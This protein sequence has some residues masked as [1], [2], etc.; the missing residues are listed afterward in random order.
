[1]T[2]HAE[3]LSNS[4]NFAIV[5]MPGRRFPGCWVAADTM[6]TWLQTLE[7]A[8]L[9]PDDGGAALVAEDLAAMLANYVRFRTASDQPLPFEWTDDRVPP[10]QS[11]DDVENDSAE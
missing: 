11:G 7:A 4:G 1:M 3:I 10:V 5:A 9:D 2:D 8:N 6:Y